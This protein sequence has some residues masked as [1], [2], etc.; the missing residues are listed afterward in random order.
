MAKV[1]GVLAGALLILWGLYF[2]RFGESSSPAEAFNRSLAEKIADVLIALV[3]ATFLYV[4]VQYTNLQKA[5]P[6]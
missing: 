5:I 2:F 1:F 6:L 3:T 4:A